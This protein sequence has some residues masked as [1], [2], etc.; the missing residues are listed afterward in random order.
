MTSSKTTIPDTN[1]HRR[2]GCAQW[3]PAAED[4]VA[5]YAVDSKEFNAFSAI[6]AAVS[7]VLIRAGAGLAATARRG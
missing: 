2:A 6:Q 5:G 4:D 7:N 1:D 3:V